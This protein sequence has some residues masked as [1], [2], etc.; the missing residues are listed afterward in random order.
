MVQS[1][2]F[3][4]TNN[5]SVRELA[6][7]IGRLYLATNRFTLYPTRPQESAARTLYRTPNN[8]N[9]PPVMNQNQNLNQNQNPNQN[10]NLN[11]N[12]NQNQGM[13]NQQLANHFDAL[14]GQNGQFTTLM[15]GLMGANG[16][17]LTGLTNA[18]NGM[19]AGGNQRESNLVKVQTFHG[20]ED[21][22][23]HE[24][25]DLFDQAKEANRWPNDRRIAI[26]AGFLRDAALD[27]YNGDRAN[28]NQWNV[29]NGNNNFV[30]RFLEHFSSET[31][32]NKWYYELMTIQQTSEENVDEYSRRFRK[33]LRRVNIN[34]LVP[35][36]LQVRM[37]LYGLNP[38]LTPLV[39]SHNPADLDAAVTRAITV[40]TGYNYVPSKKV[41]INVPTAVTVNRVSR[42]GRR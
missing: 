13:N 27:W 1:I 2:E 18:I 8:N 9:T 39:S 35:A 29:N 15:N 32:Q 24:W 26:A 23:P 33:L 4:R 5:L 6:F 16:A 10:Q 37:F 40:E 11:Q 34:D 19:N 20:K 7:I 38:L 41:S 36:A 42:R 21:D 14:F 3:Q 12:Q 25:I 17:N 30:T 22:D 28:I 31:K